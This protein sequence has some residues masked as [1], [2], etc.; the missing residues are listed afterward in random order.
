MLGRSIHDP[1]GVE[2]D[3]RF[4]PG[5][6][7]LPCRTTLAAAKTTAVRNGTTSNGIP[8]SGYEIHMGRTAIEATLPAFARFSDGSEDGVRLPRLI[9]TYLHGAFEHSAVC[10]DVFGITPTE[11]PDKVA[12][13]ARLAD[14][15][16]HHVRRASDLGLT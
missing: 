13:Y 14:W 5:L 7:L 16:E 9:G 6:D 1:L 10:S 2:S 8:V 4:A 12:Q 15:F 3:V 11:V